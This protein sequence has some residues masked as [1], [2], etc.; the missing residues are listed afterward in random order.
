MELSE[1]FEVFNYCNN[2]ICIKSDDLYLI[3]QLLIQMLEEEGYISIPQPSLPPNLTP[4]FS[5]KILASSYL[6]NPYIWVFGLYFNKLLEG[7]TVIKTSIPEF[8]CSRKKGSTVPRLSNLATLSNCEVFYHSVINSHYGVLLEANTYGE[9][10][11][12]GYVDCLDLDNMMFYNEPVII[13]SREKNFLLLNVSDNFQQAGISKVRLS[14]E[15]REKRNLELEAIVK[16]D[17]GALHIF[18]PE[19]R[20]INMGIRESIDRD[21]CHLLCSSEIYWNTNDLLYKSYY[22]SEMLENLGIKLLFFQV[23]AFEFQTNTGE[24]W[25]LL[26]NFSSQRFSEDV[27]KIFTRLNCFNRY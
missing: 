14:K 10:L 24:I 17:P 9:T 25:D 12:S 20:E 3:E 19:Y 6:T 5:D 22:E 23:G 4:S 8:F 26:T 15:E 21:L 2:T 13:F 27:E 11:A 16:E 7:W 1:Y 18:A